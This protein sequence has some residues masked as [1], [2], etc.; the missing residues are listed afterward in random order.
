MTENREDRTEQPTR[1]RRADA[2]EEG[3]VAHSRDLQTGLF[4]L[5]LS[6]VIALAGEALTSA[7]AEVLH[8]SLTQI[9]SSDPALTPQTVRSRLGGSLMHLVISLWPFWLVLPLTAAAATILQRGWIF[10]PQQVLPNA[11]RL[12]PAHGLSRLLSLESLGRIAAVIVK[13]TLLGALAWW[14]AADGSLLGELAMPA[15]STAVLS[16]V[17]PSRSI[18]ILTAQTVSLVQLSARLTFSLG[19][20]LLMWGGIDFLLQLRKHERSLMMTP[21]EV[22]DEQERQQTDPAVRRRIDSARN[23]LSDNLLVQVAQANIVLLDTS[24]SG[25]RALAIC[26]AP[27]TD[28]LPRVVASAENQSAAH[29]QQL[30]VARAITLVEQPELVR[31]LWREASDGRAI[32]PESFPTLAELLAQS[33]AAGH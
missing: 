13:F 26:F 31:S 33:N 22:R 29:L 21:Q 11:G 2:R 17:E 6:G 15:K 23:S 3:R 7:P 18:A 1:R 28:Q 4:V 32:P 5:A 27:E 25:P 12:N 19:A 10:H 24:A 14:W 20:G 16:T 9:D 8:N 30:A